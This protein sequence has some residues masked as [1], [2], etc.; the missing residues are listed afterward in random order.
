MAPW[1][2]GKPCLLCWGAM[3]DRLSHLQSAFRWLL[4]FT[5][6]RM[7]WITL[8]DRDLQRLELNPIN[9]CYACEGRDVAI[10]FVEAC[11]T[12]YFIHTL[13]LA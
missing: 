5:C 13:L 9:F 3:S 2:P 7:I 12:R 10:T 4:A 1:G 8:I 11:I 6:T